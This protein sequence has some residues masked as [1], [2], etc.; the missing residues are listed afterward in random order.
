MAS[1]GS[2]PDVP[3]PAKRPERSETVEPEDI[4]VGEEGEVDKK[5]GRRALMRPRAAA[6]NTQGSSGGVGTGLSA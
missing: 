4:A 6:A 5:K 3:N 2:A 1:G